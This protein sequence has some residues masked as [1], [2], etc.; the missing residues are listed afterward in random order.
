MAL[1]EVLADGRDLGQVASVV[2]L[3]A[4]QL[5][6]GVLVDVGRLAVLASEIAES[7]PESDSPVE[8][9]QNYDSAGS[10]S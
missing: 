9:S 8:S 1:L 6:G 2:E 4:G 7:Y 3:E 5:S 10:N